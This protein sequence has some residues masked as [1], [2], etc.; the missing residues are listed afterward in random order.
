MQIKYATCT[1]STHKLYKK[2]G[3]FLCS[4]LYKFQ[5]KNVDLGS[6]GGLICLEKHLTL[7]LL[8]FP[9]IKKTFQSLPENTFIEN[10]FYLLF[11]FTD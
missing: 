4:S 8:Q 11:C 9:K 3:T 6:P 1:L 10:M 5:I 2:V 7:L